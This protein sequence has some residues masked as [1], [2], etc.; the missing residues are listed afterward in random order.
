MSY[1]RL[2][3]QGKLNFAFN[4]PPSIARRN[5][6]AVYFGGHTLLGSL[7]LGC[8]RVDSVTF[9][10]IGNGEE[11]MFTEYGGVRYMT[12]QHSSPQLVLSV[13][14]SKD[15]DIST[16]L[17]LMKIKINPYNGQVA[18]V[19]RMSDT[20]GKLNIDVVQFH[21]TGKVSR[22]NRFEK[23]TLST[24][25]YGELGYESIEAVKINITF[26]IGKWIV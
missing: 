5:M 22:V 9:P 7:D 20:S 16:L 23:C 24:A 10:D 14:E 12:P 8:D 19:R 26:N 3:E 1:S 4:R 6:Y 2:G 25:S 11:E 15:H 18:K 13:L 21:M 17:A